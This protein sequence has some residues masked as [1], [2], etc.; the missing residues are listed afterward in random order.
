LPFNDAVVT[1]IAQDLRGGTVRG[2]LV[3]QIQNTPPEVADQRVQVYKNTP[4]VVVTTLGAD[5]EPTKD[6][7]GQFL[8]LQ[9][10]DGT[11][12]SSI[13]G[14]TCALASENHEIIYS[15]PRDYLGEDELTFFITDGT[16]GPS[17]KSNAGRVLID[18]VEDPNAIN[19]AGDAAG[20][21]G[22]LPATGSNPMNQFA[23][24]VI[25]ICVGAWFAMAGRRRRELALSLP[26]GRHYR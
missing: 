14:G 10:Q 6:V 20:A 5:G 16:Q 11:T 2:R 4:R 21:A 19:V 24:G 26:P 25:A 12:G 1:Y 3:V 22:S 8:Q 23:A 15:P 7:N 18:V 9:C 17:S 13:K